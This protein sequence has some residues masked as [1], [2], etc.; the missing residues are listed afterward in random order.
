M[1]IFTN[2]WTKRFFQKYPKKNSP[3]NNDICGFIDE[4][5]LFQNDLKKRALP[6]N[7]DIDIFG[8]MGKNNFY[9]NYDIF[10]YIFSKQSQKSFIFLAMLIC[11]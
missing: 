5:L 4:K 6:R 10:G 11:T 3:R 7:Y 9:G 2:L 8:Y 1:L